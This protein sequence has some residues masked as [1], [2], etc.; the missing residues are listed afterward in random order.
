METQFVV[1]GGMC[2]KPHVLDTMPVLVSGEE[3]HFCRIV[4]NETWFLKCGAGA[5]AQKGILNMSA[6]IEQLKDKLADASQNMTQGSAGAEPDP[7][8]A[9]DPMSALDEVEEKESPPTMK[10]APTRLGNTVFQIEMP[11]HPPEMAGT[12]VADLLKVSV[13]GKSTNQVWIAVEDV[14]WLINYVATEV[15]L[16]GVPQV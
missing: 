12:A 16:G 8:V 10:Y 14:E 13:L 5:A 4:K 1:R 11:Q 15:A 3:R 9:D 2:N 7:A 6:V